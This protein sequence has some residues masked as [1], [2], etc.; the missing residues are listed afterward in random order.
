MK[1]IFLFLII[2]LVQQLFA[3]ITQDQINIKTIGS[4]I[5]IT[6]NKGFHINDKAPASAT[7]DGLQ[8]IYKPKIKTEQKLSFQAFKAFKNL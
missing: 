5:E 1:N 4:T 3:G 7:Y 8:T 2:F 6:P